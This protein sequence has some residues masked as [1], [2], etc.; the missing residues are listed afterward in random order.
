MSVYEKMIEKLNIVD[1]KIIVY[2]KV[3]EMECCE[4]YRTRI[5]SNGG[6][7]FYNIITTSFKIVKDYYLNK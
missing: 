5:L 3:H 7:W 4:S 2:R 1:N 6:Q